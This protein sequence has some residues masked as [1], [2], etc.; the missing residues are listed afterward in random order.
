MAI[1]D[2]PSYCLD[3]DTAAAAGKMM[4]SKTMWQ[5]TH[6]HPRWPELQHADFRLKHKADFLYRSENMRLEG[7]SEMCLAKSDLMVHRNLQ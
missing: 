7:G 6:D 5:A 1:R 3:L 2:D 4:I